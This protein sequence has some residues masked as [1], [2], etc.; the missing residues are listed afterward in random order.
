MKD[1]LFLITNLNL[2]NENYLNTISQAL[3][4]GVDAVVLREKELPAK[5]LYSLAL[6]VREITHAKGKRLI[7]ND[8]VDVA[9]AVGADGVQLG[10]HSLSPKAARKACSSKMLLGAS[11]HSIEEAKVAVK[12]GADY[13]LVSHI[14]PTQCKPG[15]IPK[16]LKLLQDISVMWE[17]P[18]VA[19]GGISASNLDQITTIGC[20]NVAVMSAI[21]ASKKPL[22]V[23]K[24]IKSQLQENA[25]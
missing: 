12:E 8:R 18:L 23:S 5:E 7:I 15:V 11:V 10:Q 21:M 24:Q 25:R 4:G 14:F 3:V 9:E 6:K 2:V 20:S 19:L 13:L 22:E 17:I 16:G 1:K